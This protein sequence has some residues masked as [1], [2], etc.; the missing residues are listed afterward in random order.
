MRECEFC[1]T[2]ADEVEAMLSVSGYAICDN[3]WHDGALET[4]GS[5]DYMYDEP[6]DHFAYFEE[7]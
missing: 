3:C 2:P 6:D 7:P 1:D 4:E 5:L